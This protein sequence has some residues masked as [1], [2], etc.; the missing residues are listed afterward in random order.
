MNLLKYLSLTL[1]A[2]VALSATLDIKTT[3]SVSCTR[4]T[5]P[6]DT[7]HMHYRG[8]LSDGSEFDSSYKRH[9]P[10]VFPVGKGVVIKGYVV[11]PVLR[12]RCSG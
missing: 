8:T 3:H 2:P 4:K 9:A 12:L 6:G 11:P 10:L 5:Q 7:V 1:L